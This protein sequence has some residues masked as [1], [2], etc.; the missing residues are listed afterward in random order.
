MQF[1]QHAMKQRLDMNANFA[2]HASGSTANSCRP[3][4]MAFGKL[5]LSSTVQETRKGPQC[6]TKSLCALVL[7]VA[8]VWLL[9]TT[10]LHHKTC[11]KFSKRLVL[12]SQMLCHPFRFVGCQGRCYPSMSLLYP[13]M[14]R[15][16]SCRRLNLFGRVWMVRMA[17][18]CTWPLPNEYILGCILPASWGTTPQSLTQHQSEV[19]LSRDSGVHQKDTDHLGYV[20]GDAC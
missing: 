10:Y 3:L 17:A 4:T 8:L 18:A 9:S 13:N 6:A 7:C 12:Y 20:A 16:G 2:A 11:G 1:P 19:S 5:H 14:L 15:L